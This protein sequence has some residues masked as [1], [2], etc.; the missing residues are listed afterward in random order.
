MPREPV[1]IIKIDPLATREELRA[2]A[3][4]IVEALAAPP[5]K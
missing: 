3:K 5:E 1:A 2:L 4:E